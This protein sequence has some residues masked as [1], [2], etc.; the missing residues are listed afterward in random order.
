MPF[1]GICQSTVCP[2]F[3]NN[4]NGRGS[5]RVFCISCD[6]SKR[7]KDL[8]KFITKKCYGNDEMERRYHYFMG[9]V[10]AIYKLP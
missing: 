2:S 3:H 9:K 1:C 5:H 6:G 7:N 4:Y 10:R 8:N